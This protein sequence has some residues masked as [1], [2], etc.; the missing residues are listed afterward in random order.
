MPLPTIGSALLD[1]AL[2]L[3]LLG[4]VVGLVRP[5]DRRLRLF[6]W[7]TFLACLPAF[8]SL[9]ALVARADPTVGYA[10][11]H[12]A[13]AGAGLGYRLAAVWAGQAGGLLLWCVE[14]ALV[15]LF[16]LPAR[17]PRA[18]AVMSAL[19]AC[20]LGLVAVS[21]PFA[22]AAAG[23]VGGMN[24]MLQ[25][26]MM[27]IHPPML[28][29][30]YALLAAPYAITIGALVDGDAEGWPKAVWPWALVAWLALTLGNGFG[31]EWAYKT[32]GWGG[33]WSWDPVE[34]TSFVPWMLVAAGV[35]C[36]WMARRNGT[37]LRPA[38]VCLAGAFVAVLYGSYLARSGALAGASVHA[39]VA[40]EKLMQYALGGLLIGATVLV[41]ALL[42]PRWKE[43]KAP[44]AGEPSDPA[45]RA[46]P[47]AIGA[48]A[49]VSV[50]VLA[51][52][53][54]PMLG[55]APTT[56][57][58]NTALMPLALVMMVMLLRARGWML[59]GAM[60]WA[61]RVVLSL[62]LIVAWAM[63][64]MFGATIDHGPGMILQAIFGPP[65]LLTACLVAL[66]AVGEILGR[67]VSWRR[68][69]APLAHLGLA[70]LL[71]GALG[72]GYG[73]ATEKAFLTL[74]QEQQVLGHWLLATAVSLP[75]PEVK[76]ANLS[77]DDAPG[78]V[79]ME[80]SKLFDVSLRRALIR[81]GLMGDL[82]V[83]PMAIVVEPMK[84]GT[85]RVPPGAMIEVAVKPVMSL[86]WLGML[87]IAA[88]L[89]LSL[90]RRS[91]AS[92]A[93]AA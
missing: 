60:R 27:L 83:T 66:Q 51:G 92:A 57:A 75:A 35:H 52:M 39:Y 54:L 44:A 82:Y 58:Y 26:P 61:A 84:M 24:P 20:L 18:V 89:L 56:A 67:G 8:L 88:G 81:R 40:G 85:I 73:S 72:S 3:A 32:F 90:A 2:A 10:V 74:G 38:A 13:P 63:A 62:W 46:T 69:G 49:A 53:S 5:G 79:E 33:F 48:M 76:R 55:T 1:L 37:W 11:E 36:L 68:R 30:G 34:N 50:L 47:H 77:M 59:G 41:A 19:E 78:R 6:Q 64:L 4:C 16:M 86:L 23:A 87:G 42:I 91:R 25:A 93:R 17:M 15:G 29:L 70:A 45:S 43:W 9:M 28:F 12:A 31:S 7:L 80:T 14:T 71:I 65:L 21:N 22:P